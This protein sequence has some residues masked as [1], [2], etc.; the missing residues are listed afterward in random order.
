[1]I[2]GDIDALRDDLIEAKAQ[3]DYYHDEC[4]QD[5]KA[6]CLKTYMPLSDQILRAR[7]A[8][9]AG[10]DSLTV[11]TLGLQALSPSGRL[12]VLTAS[13]QK[14]GHY[15][16]TRFDDE[17]APWGD[18]NYGSKAAALADFVQESDLATIQ[19]YANSRILPL[20][21]LTLQDANLLPPRPSR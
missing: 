10:L 12:L 7:K 16:L 18:T 8:F 6:P 4:R 17:G 3:F 9:L 13:A 11:D 2:E 14:P 5:H 19:D 1:M 21:L 15:Q 20:E